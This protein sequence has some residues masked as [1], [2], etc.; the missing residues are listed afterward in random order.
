M[1]APLRQKVLSSALRTVPGKWEVFNTYLRNG[2]YEIPKA[3]TGDPHRKII[4]V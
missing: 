4:H 3:K 2:R 1:K